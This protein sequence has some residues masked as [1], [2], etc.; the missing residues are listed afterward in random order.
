[1]VITQKLLLHVQ[2]HNSTAH[3]LC[4][5]CTNC[6]ICNCS[7]LTV[8]TQKLLLHIQLHNNTTHLLY[9][10][11]TNCSLQPNC[12]YSNIT[13]AAATFSAAQQHS[14]FTVLLL[15]KLYSLQLFLLTIITQKLLLHVQLPSRRE[16]DIL[17]SSDVKC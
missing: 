10:Y 12:T 2:L 8:I 17:M 13:E 6:T 1:M 3:L 7:I 14:T 11:C 9:K 4:K 16:S 15:Y 5:S